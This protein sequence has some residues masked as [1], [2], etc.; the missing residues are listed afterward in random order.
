[1]KSYFSLLAIF[2][3]LIVLT[4][5]PIEQVSTP[6]NFQ[7]TPSS[8]RKVADSAPIEVLCDSADQMPFWYKNSEGSFVQ[9]CV[10]KPPPGPLPVICPKGT[11]LTTDRVGVKRICIPPPVPIPDPIV[12]PNPTDIV[13]EQMITENGNSRTIY[14]C[15]ENNNCSSTTGENCCTNVFHPERPIKNVLLSKVY[16]NFRLGFSEDKIYDKGTDKKGEYVCIYPTGPIGIN[17][18]NHWGVDTFCGDYS[19]SCD[20]AY[21]CL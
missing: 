7:T 3:G 18:P 6:N 12:C 17:D 14:V 9:V 13:T 10:A 1:M 4:G 11:V 20:T 15:I 21:P 19:T 16:G 2:L 8:D 5:C